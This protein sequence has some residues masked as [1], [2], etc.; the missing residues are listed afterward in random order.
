MEGPPSKKQKKVVTG[1]GD[2]GK[3]IIP[4][5]EVKK[6]IDSLKFTQP[7]SVL[8]RK[9]VSERKP[10]VKCDKRRQYYCYDCLQLTN[11]MARAVDVKL[12]VDVHVL[13]HAGEHRGKATSVQ[14]AVM[15]SNVHLYTHPELPKDIKKEETLLVYPSPEAQ[16]LSQLAESGALAS[17]KNLV[18]VDSTWQQ[19]KGICRDPAVKALGIPVLLEKYRTLFWR[20]Q[21]VGD[22]TFLATIEAIYYLVRDLQVAKGETYKGEFDDLLYYYIHQYAVIQRSYK[23]REH[24][25]KHEHA[26]ERP[27]FTK[28]HQKSSEY[29]RTEVDFSYLLNDADAEDVRKEEP[30]A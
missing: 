12:P 9:E 18:F 1:T 7:V 23:D 16:S 19:S 6:F 28:R 20:F 4:A 3:D 21:N 14:G 17:I 10:C 25:K 11:P 2:V 5:E 15:S 22:E 26:T 24:Q 27:H 8:E 30:I 29:I 13:L